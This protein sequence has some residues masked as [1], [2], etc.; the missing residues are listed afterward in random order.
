MN[1]GL[2]V[3]TPLTTMSCDK[4]TPTKKYKSVPENYKV[5]SETKYHKVIADLEAVL[6]DI[7]TDGVGF[8]TLDGKI[9]ASTLKNWADYL[10]DALETLTKAQ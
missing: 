9:S 6:L 1:T 3:T 5:L 4:T 8:N 7:S 2:T 10:R